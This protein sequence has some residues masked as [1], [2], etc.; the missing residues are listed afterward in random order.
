MNGESV[1]SEWLAR[2]QQG[3]VWQ[4][5]AAA[6]DSWGQLAGADLL[7]LVNEA[8]RESGRVNGIFACYWV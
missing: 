8:A 6:F 7:W 1:L 5:Q 3:R 2:L 4:R